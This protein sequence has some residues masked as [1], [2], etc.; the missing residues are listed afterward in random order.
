MGSVPKLRVV[1]MLSD[2][3]CLQPMFFIVI[4]TI[5]FLNDTTSG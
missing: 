4:V 3:I 5:S 2:A 1:A